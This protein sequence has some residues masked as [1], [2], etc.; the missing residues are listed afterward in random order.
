M[1]EGLIK[2]LLEEGEIA[3]KVSSAG[4]F[5][6]EDLPATSFAVEAMK[7]VG[8]DISMHRTRQVN[9]QLIKASDHVVGISRRHVEILLDRYPEH[10]PRICSFPLPDIP[11]PFGNGLETYRAVRV[12]LL[13]WSR[14][15]LDCLSES[16]APM[17]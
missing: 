5:T 10:A 3:G 8:I 17:R 11:D 16:A 7:E 9:E 6:L 12:L 15:L 13:D 2:R 1:A 4:L 14:T